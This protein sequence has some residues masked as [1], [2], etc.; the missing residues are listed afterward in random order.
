LTVAG[1]GAAALA[2]LGS[3]PVLTHAAARPGRVGR[4]PTRALRVASIALTMDVE[5]E[6]RRLYPIDASP[7]F[8]SQVDSALRAGSPER[9]AIGRRGFEVDSEGLVLPL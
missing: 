5:G 7:D 6:P 4:D 8:R 9:S 2:I 3:L 1:R